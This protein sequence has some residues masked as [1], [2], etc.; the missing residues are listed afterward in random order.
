MNFLTSWKNG[1][2]S[3][4][5]LDT[6]VVEVTESRLSHERIN[7]LEVLARLHLKGFKLSID[8]FG[9]GYSSLYRVKDI[10]FSELKIDQSFVQGALADSSARA[11]IR[12]S[13]QLA[14][15]LGMSVIAEGVEAKE[16]QVLIEEMGCSLMQGFLFAKPQAFESVQEMLVAQ[17][18]DEATKQQRLSIL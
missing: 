16:N 3:G 14:E 13:L 1:A 2:D 18:A 7:L 10:P 11:V 4:I 9:T 17:V 8:D 15:D 5:A 6:I 12:S